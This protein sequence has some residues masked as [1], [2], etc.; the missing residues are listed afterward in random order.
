MRT[1][2]TDGTP[3]R[4]SDQGYT[5]AAPAHLGDVSMMA[6]RRAEIVVGYR[7]ASVLI[8]EL[9]AEFEPLTIRIR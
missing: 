9:F 7:G 8:G 1:A 4:R 5:I 3:V 6:S 2:S